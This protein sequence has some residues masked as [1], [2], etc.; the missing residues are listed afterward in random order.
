MT[1]RHDDETVA[2]LHDEILTGKAEIAKLRDLLTKENKRANDAIA[3]EDTAEQAAEEAHAE[4][5]HARAALR[6][7]ADQLGCMDYDTDSNDYGYDTYRDAWNG[8]VMDAADRLRRMADEAGRD[9][10]EK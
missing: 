9:G 2:R 3:R 4:L 10:G 7:A 1:N 8:G 6:E 5:R